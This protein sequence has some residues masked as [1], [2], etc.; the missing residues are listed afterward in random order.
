MRREWVSDKVIE[1]ILRDFP[2]K[3]E[4]RR[5]NLSDPT[6]VKHHP[7]SV[8]RLHDPDQMTQLVL[9]LKE[10]ADPFSK[11]NITRDASDLEWRMINTAPSYRYVLRDPETGEVIDEERFVNHVDTRDPKTRAYVARLN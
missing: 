10:I 7:E 6:W 5:Q 9:T 11:V 2:A 4:E 8:K 1:E 3:I